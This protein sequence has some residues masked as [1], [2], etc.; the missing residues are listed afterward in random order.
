MES[1]GYFLTFMV[2]RLTCIWWNSSVIYSYLLP[3]ETL[4]L[5][6]DQNRPNIPYSSS[7]S[8]ISGH[9]SPRETPIPINGGFLRKAWWQDV[10]AA[11]RNSRLV[12]LIK[13]CVQLKTPGNKK[14][15]LSKLCY[16]HLFLTFVFAFKKS[17]KTLLEY[18]PCI[19]YHFPLGMVFNAHLV[20]NHCPHHLYHLLC[21]LPVSR[22]NTRTR[23]E[24]GWLRGADISSPSI[25][26]A[27]PSTSKRRSSN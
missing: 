2:P 11:S 5:R 3:V 18:K 1:M 21:L 24:V 17:P 6:M 25:G 16:S 12:L 4:S 19:L 7:P 8:L 27:L 20:S 10:S 26:S 22:G 13:S 23:P 9:C 15:P 14:I